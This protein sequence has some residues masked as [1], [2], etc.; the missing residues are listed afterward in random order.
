[1]AKKEDRDMKG[2]II[3]LVVFAVVLALTLVNQT[4]PPGRALYNC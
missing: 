1:V 4:I 2:A 3:F